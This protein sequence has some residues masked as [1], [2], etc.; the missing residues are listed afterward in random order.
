MIL[1]NNKDKVL[2][3]DEF[4]DALDND[5]SLY[6]QLNAI[7]V[8]SQKKGDLFAEKEDKAT[9]EKKAECVGNIH[10]PYLEVTLSS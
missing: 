1:A 3:W 7:L 10:Q 2:D 5:K 8:N 6:E 4:I 9:G